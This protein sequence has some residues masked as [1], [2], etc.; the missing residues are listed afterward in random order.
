[1]AEVVA[2][3][4]DCDFVFADRMKRV[5]AEENPTLTAFDETAWAAR[6]FY[7]E[8]AVPEYVSLLTAN[9][10]AVAAILRRLSDADFARRGSHSVL[11]AVTLADILAK[12]VNH[13]DHHLKFI[14]AKRAKLG[15]ALPPRYG[16]EA[17]GT[18]V[19][20]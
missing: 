2:H 15:V 1:M 12:A 6:L 20:G 4:G 13:I 3:L 19:T 7:Q 17:L 16:S 8:I 18:L 9:R 11:G 14:Y 10:R 5:I